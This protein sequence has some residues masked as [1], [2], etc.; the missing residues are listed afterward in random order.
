MLLKDKTYTI[1]IGANYDNHKLYDIKLVVNESID[2]T[3][4]LRNIETYGVQLENVDQ[5]FIDYA[6]NSDAGSATH[7]LIVS[8]PIVGIPIKIK[9]NSREIVFVDEGKSNLRLFI[10]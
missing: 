8:N 1:S 6:V 4:V 10:K 5:S 9:E 2:L 7:E 3:E